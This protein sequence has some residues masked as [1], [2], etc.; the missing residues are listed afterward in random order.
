M[1]RETRKP[2]R[3]GNTAAV[4]YDRLRADILSG[5]LKPGTPLS[6]LKIARDGG[7]SRGP[8]REAMKRLEQD[9]LIIG[10]ANRRFSVAPFDIA[11]L[12][13]VLTLTLVNT[14]LAMRVG[15]P[16]LSDHDLA[17]LSKCS[18]QMEAF[19]SGD[20]ELW[21]LAYRGFTSVLISPAGGRVASVVSNLLDNI[22]R[23]RANL[24]HRFPRV[25]A[26]GEEIQLI[27]EAARKRDGVRASALYVH[28]FGRVCSLILAGAA[29]LHDAFRL[30]GYVSALE[31]GFEPLQAG[32]VGA[33]RAAPKRRSTSE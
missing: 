27:V 21:E 31:P 23:Y 6:Q 13:A 26:G 17:T 22:Q 24:L 33:A 8:V 12:E 20:R 14:A 4:V 30:R 11:D 10:F 15:V 29:P 1:A 3:E 9:Q 7:T 25:D 32:S 18:D 16:K 5:T 28:F 2:T 19:A